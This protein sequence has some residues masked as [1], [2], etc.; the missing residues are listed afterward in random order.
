MLRQPPTE[1]FSSRVEHYTRFRPGYPKQT[2][3]VLRDQCG[4][5]TDSLVADVA[6]GTGLFTRLLLENGNRVIGI[7]PN[8]EMRRGGEKFLSDFP[9]FTSVNG[10]AEATTLFDRSLDFVTAAQA[11]HW[12]DRDKSLQ[13][14]RRILR[15]GGYLVLLWNDRLVDSAGFNRDYEQLVLQYG[16]D[17][18][19]VKRRDAAAAHFF[20][21]IPFAKRVLPNYQHLDFEALKGRLLSSSYIPQPGEPSYEEMIAALHRLFE[22]YQ[23]DQRVQMEYD[24]KMYFTNFAPEAGE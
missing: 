22:T 13:E 24:T 11:A 20:C 12:F 5:T 8:A 19:E 23:C 6:F 21:D 16:T 18:G 4:L 3:T 9:R 1:R 7:E 17:Y 14:F 15:P 2:I 10:T